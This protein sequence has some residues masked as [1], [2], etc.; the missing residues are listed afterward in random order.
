M[1]S[2]TYSLIASVVLFSS[3][4]DVLLSK[5]MKQVGEITSY[6]PSVLYRVFLRTFTSPTIWLGIFSLVIFFVS[7]LLLL[8][9]ADFSFVQ[10]VCSIGYAGVAVLSYFL[11]GEIISPT[12]WI[13]VLLICAG[14]ALVSGTQPRTAGE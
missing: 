6:A 1:N 8:S 3:L 5:G 2:K 14:V 12:R 11:L 13:G 10:P 4:G 7:Y 9:W